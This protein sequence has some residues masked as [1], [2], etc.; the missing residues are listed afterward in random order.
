MKRFLTFLIASALLLSYCSL[1][2]SADT[3]NEYDRLW[4]QKSAMG[5]DEA[6]CNHT[7]ESW[8]GSHFYVPITLL[9]LYTEEAKTFTF[10]IVGEDFEIDEMGNS[11][12]YGSE[13]CRY[14]EK[15]GA[16]VYVKEFV[17]IGKQCYQDSWQEVFPP[18]Y[19][20]VRAFDINREE[21]GE[22]YQK[23]K[24][25][26]E[27]IRSLLSMLTDEEFEKAIAGC[28]DL[29][30][31]AWLF[32]ALYLENKKEVQALLCR[33]SGTYLDGEYVLVDEIIGGAYTM[34]ELKEKGLLTREFRCLIKTARNHRYFTGAKEQLLLEIE[35]YLDENPENIL[36]KAGDETAVYALIFTLCTLPLAGL[37]VYGWKKRRA[38]I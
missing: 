28:R 2:S 36:P 35:A 8:Y 27:S 7:E 24:N 32:D 30:Y 13:V 10:G 18:I 37:C 20:F 21:L 14:D 33:C 12:T 3:E 15:D 23:M 4:A 11:P 29:D 16:S 1:F 31:P 26:P 22:A 5:I 38:G 6:Y 34:E 17:E 19:Y 25:E 9:L